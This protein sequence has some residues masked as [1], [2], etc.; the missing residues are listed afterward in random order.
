[1]RGMIERLQ[2]AKEDILEL[3]AELHELDGLDRLGRALDE[4]IDLM[5]GRRDELPPSVR[6]F[7]DELD[8]LDDAA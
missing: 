4:L 2:A 8:E 7:L 5:Q 6:H 3:E 1:M